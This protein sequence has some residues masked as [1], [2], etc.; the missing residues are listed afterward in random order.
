MPRREATLVTAYGTSSPLFRMRI[1][2]NSDSFNLVVL[3]INAVRRRRNIHGESGL[4]EYIYVTFGGHALIGR[5][6]ESKKYTKSKEYLGAGRYREKGIMA[7][8]YILSPLTV[9]TGRNKKF[10][11]L[12]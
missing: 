2:R 4:V 3:V 6:I 7:R 1:L 12:D 5:C 8:P 9:A 10:K 11:V